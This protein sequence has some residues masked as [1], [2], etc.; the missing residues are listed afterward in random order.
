MN[1]NEFL[2]NLPTTTRE[3]QSDI[4][5]ALNAGKLYVSV[6]TKNT[7][8]HFK[9]YFRDGETTTSKQ[10]K[11]SP[12]SKDYILKNKELIEFSK[13]AKEYLNLK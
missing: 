2:S 3:R 8:K 9:I 4:Q 6:I 13:D 11:C 10:L 12:N 1:I 7:K 5:D